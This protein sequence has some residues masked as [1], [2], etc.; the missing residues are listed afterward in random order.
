MRLFTRHHPPL[1]QS[2]PRQRAAAPNSAPASDRAPAD[3]RPAGC[4]W[5]DSSHD[6]QHGLRVTEHADDDAVARLVPLSW[7][8]AWELDAALATSAARARV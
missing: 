3:D 7:W 8:L 1:P 2:L 5:F 6:L 4:G